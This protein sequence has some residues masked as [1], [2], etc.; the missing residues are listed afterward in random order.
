MIGDGDVLVAQTGG[1][2]YH[3]RQRI[4]PVTVGAVHV[5][6]TADVCAFDHPRQRPGSSRLQ[7]AG[8]VAQLRRYPR[9]ARPRVDILL[10]CAP[11]DSLRPCL[12]RHYVRP[13][14]CRRDEKRAEFGQ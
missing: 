4:P 6:I 2:G 10:T 3:V 7:L 14:P 13:G 1:R 8:V 5:K 12:Q 11:A 9:Q